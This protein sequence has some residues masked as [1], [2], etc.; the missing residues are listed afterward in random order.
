MIG[1]MKMRQ[2]GPHRRMT[3]VRLADGRLP[4]SSAILLDE[5]EMTALESYGALAFLVVPGEI[6]RAEE[7]EDRTPS[8]LI[9]GELGHSTEA[10]RPAL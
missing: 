2:S 6:R 8:A 1:T 3:I 4:I 5:I 7:G 9:G 10:L